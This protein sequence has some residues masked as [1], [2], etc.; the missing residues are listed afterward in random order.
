MIIIA[1]KHELKLRHRTRHEIQTKSW[2]KNRNSP[3]QLYAHR[4]KHKNEIKWMK[5][6]V[7]MSR[8]NIIQRM[9]NSKHTWGS[10]MVN[11]S[12][13]V[14][15]DKAPFLVLCAI[16]ITHWRLHSIRLYSIFCS[17]L[18]FHFLVSFFYIFAPNPLADLITQ[19]KLSSQNKGVM[20]LYKL[21]TRTY[22][23][24]L[25]QHRQV[26]QDKKLIT[27]VKLN[28]MKSVISVTFRHISF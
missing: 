26:S 7:N 3:T 25:S 1:V 22:H 8:S 27:K 16:Y 2:A 5:Q 15:R 18:V 6:G 24:L 20:L 19:C 12:I 4:I 13:R 23:A 21:T 9:L 28:Q 11:C 10:N 17:Y 14:V